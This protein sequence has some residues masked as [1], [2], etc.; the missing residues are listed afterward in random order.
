[1]EQ[2]LAGLALMAIGW[3]GRQVWD[4]F[5]RPQLEVCVERGSALRAR[6]DP[7]DPHH[8]QMVRDVVLTV[9]NHGRRAAVDCVGWV[10]DLEFRRNG[11]WESFTSRPPAALLWEGTGDSQCATVRPTSEAPPRRLRVFS[12]VEHPDGSQ[13]GFFAYAD[14]DE[15]RTYPYTAPLHMR[16]TVWV[17]PEGEEGQPDFCQLEVEWTCETDED[18]QT[19]EEIDVVAAPE[20]DEISGRWW[21]L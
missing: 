9:R 17:Q 5:R 1:M 2:I 3:F 7:L 21:G 13:Q 19:R 12:F 10:Q 16:S 8:V 4:R 18:G 20:C 15:H 6:P 14:P 11:E